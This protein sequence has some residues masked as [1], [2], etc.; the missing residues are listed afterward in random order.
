ML[1]DLKYAIGTAKQ[2]VNYNKITN[3]LILH[4]RKTHENGGDIADMI[5]NQEPFNFDSLHPNSRYQ[6]LS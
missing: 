6:Q 2:A 4:V 3:F 5:D 1:N